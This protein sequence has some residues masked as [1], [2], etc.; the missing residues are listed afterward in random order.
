MLKEETAV[1][2]AAYAYASALK[3]M[4]ETR[5][6]DATRAYQA[7]KSDL[8]STAAELMDVREEERSVKKST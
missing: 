7:A 4:N 6:S 1:L 8:A 3:K 2:H 5:T